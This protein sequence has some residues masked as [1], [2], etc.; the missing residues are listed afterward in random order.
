MATT[1]VLF[2][3]FL[4]KR[5]YLTT[6]KLQIYNINKISKVQICHKLLQSYFKAHKA[7]KTVHRYSEIRVFYILSFLILK[8]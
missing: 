8:C 5:R 4:Q 7:K 6:E 2:S 1:T 3:N